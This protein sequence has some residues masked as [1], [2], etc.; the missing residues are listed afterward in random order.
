MQQSITPSVEMHLHQQS[1]FGGKVRVQ[2]HFIQLSFLIYKHTCHEMNFLSTLFPFLEK[3][4]KQ[5]VD[6]PSKVVL[7]A[8]L[9]FSL[10]SADKWQKK[11]KK[12][13]KHRQGGFSISVLILLNSQGYIDSLCHRRN[14]YISIHWRIQG[15][16]QGRAPPSGGP[17]SFIFMQFSAKN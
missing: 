3:R 16:R 10:G 1:I 15:G 13:K 17:N 7:G 5:N 6:S 9:K 2:L 8:H 4:Q 14:K 12:K 11:K